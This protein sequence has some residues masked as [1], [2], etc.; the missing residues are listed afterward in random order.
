MKKISF[1]LITG[2]ILLSCKKFDQGGLVSKTSKNLE[3]KTWKL[4]KYYRD[5]V[6]ETTML[7][8]TNFEETF[9]NDGSLMR[10]YTDNDGEQVSETGKWTS[11][12]DD[13]LL[14]ISDVSSID[15]LD[16]IST[17][18]SSEYNILK[19]KKDEFWYTYEN[20]GSTHEF[21]MVKK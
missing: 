2:L 11:Q 5:G 1:L 19:L 13:K 12:K 21:R 20:G 6:D 7:L 10:S 16:E 14:K 4:D 9:N 17:V 3:D 15:L 18:S 8:I